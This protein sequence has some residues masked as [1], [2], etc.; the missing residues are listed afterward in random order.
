MGSCARQRREILGPVVSTETGYRLVQVSMSMDRYDDR[1]FGDKCNIGCCCRGVGY[2]LTGA[3]SK[4][5]SVR[6]SLLNARLRV[7][8]LV[9]MSAKHRREECRSKPI[10]SSDR[11]RRVDCV[12]GRV[13]EP[14][15]RRHWHQRTGCA[16]CTAEDDVVVGE[17]SVDCTDASQAVK[18][19]RPSCATTGTTPTV[20][21]RAELVT[22]ICTA[23]C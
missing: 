4:G 2:P 7:L 6:L 1:L 21:F 19:P 15:G 17:A 10:S 3:R 16:G 5:D 18:K 13:S 20:L 8:C 23:P 22:A 12:D 11:A 9:T 14:F